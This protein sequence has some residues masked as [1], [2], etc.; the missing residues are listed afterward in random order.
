MVRNYYPN[1]SKRF[2]HIYS[3]KFVLGKFWRVSLDLLFPR[4]CLGCDQNGI[5][6]CQN[7]LAHLPRSYSPTENKI[8]SVFEYGSPVVK[9]VIWRLK[10]KQTLELAEVLAKPLVD[11]LLEELEDE[12]LVTPKIVLIPVPL[13][14]RRLRSR[15]Y[16]QAEKLA[17]QMALINP[18]QFKVRIDLVRKIKDTPTQVSIKNRSERLANLKGAFAF[19]LPDLGLTQGLAGKVVVIIDDVST[20]GATINE[21]RRLVQRAGGHHVYGLVVAHG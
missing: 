20:T 3:L 11:V 16:N 17:K 15:R 2:I 19:H 5:W 13:S 12:L 14:S 8:F 21:I 10:Y 4:H 7:C 6:L 18:D 1:F 9:Q